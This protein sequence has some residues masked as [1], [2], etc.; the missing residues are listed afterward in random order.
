MARA[1]KNLC[2]PQRLL[3]AGGEEAAG[4]LAPSL[5]ALLAAL[6]A[7]ARAARLQLLAAPLAAEGS[8]WRVRAAL[9]AQLGE[10]AACMDTDARALWQT[11]LFRQRALRSVGI[12]RSVF[13]S[14]PASTL[15]RW[16][17]CAARRSCACHTANV[18]PALSCVKTV[19]HISKKARPRSTSI[20]ALLAVLFAALSATSP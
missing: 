11:C 16:A 4:G 6:P 5:A 10:A 8:N 9:A 17:V 19:E 13:C 2:S 18:R 20:V 15:Q 3:E 1:V 7:R 14:W 12:K